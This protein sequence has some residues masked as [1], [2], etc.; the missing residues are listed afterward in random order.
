MEEDTTHT[1]EVPLAEQGLPSSGTGHHQTNVGE[2]ND[3]IVAAEHFNLVPPTTP[4]RSISF[5]VPGPGHTL[6]TSKSPVEQ[7]NIY[8][9]LAQQGSGAADRAIDVLIF[10]SI[11][12]ANTST[13]GSRGIRGKDP[14]LLTPEILHLLDRLEPDK[15]KQAKRLTCHL[16]HQRHLPSTEHELHQQLE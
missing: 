13:S 7:R 1:R 16:T 9:V 11:S 2:E 6:S 14:I 5:A 4:L 15:G 8:D 10:G 12:G 3:H